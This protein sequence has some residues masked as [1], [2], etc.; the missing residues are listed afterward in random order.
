MMPLPDNAPLWA[1]FLAYAMVKTFELLTAYLTRKDA[2]QDRDEIKA[3]GKAATVLS[4]KTLAEVARTG[5]SP[6]EAVIEETNRELDR[7][8]NAGLSRT[9]KPGIIEDAKR[10]A[11]AALGAQEVQSV[12]DERFDRAERTAHRAGND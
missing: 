10:T 2:K 8:L 6:V 4:S 9:T 1:F 11:T 12:T 5:G 7:A 3:F